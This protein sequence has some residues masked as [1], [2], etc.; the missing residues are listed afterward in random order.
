MTQVFGISKFKNALEDAYPTINCVDD[1]KSNLDNHIKQFDELS[2]M[3][4]EYA[5]GNSEHMQQLEDSII[6]Y[7][8]SLSN[9][10]VAL[11]EMVYARSV[12]IDES[13]D[14][15]NQTIYAMKV[16]SVERDDYPGSSNEYRKYNSFIRIGNIVVPSE[17][18]F[19]KLSRWL[20]KQLLG[21]IITDYDSVDNI[22][23]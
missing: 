1:I 11:K 8:T 9:N 7:A 23:V 18:K 3:Y 4:I 17:K 14:N 21:I 2:A 13:L 5:S 12:S 22:T 6:K 15:I 10:L 19:N 20:W 16:K